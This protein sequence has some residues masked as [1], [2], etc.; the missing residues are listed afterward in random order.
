[1]TKPESEK[2]GGQRRAPNEAK[3]GQARQTSSGKKRSASWERAADHVG[4]AF[5]IIEV[6]D[7]LTIAAV[8]PGMSADEAALRYHGTLIDAGPYKTYDDAYDALED[9]LEEREDR[10]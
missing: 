9:L 6:E 2:T 1:M 10:D 5:A 8:D 4:E 7:G 3:S